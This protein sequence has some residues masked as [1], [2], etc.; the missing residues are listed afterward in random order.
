MCESQL[1]CEEL[2]LAADLPDPAI[3]PVDPSL[4][5]GEPRL[6]P[7][8]PRKATLNRDNQ[9][10]KETDNFLSLRKIEW[11]D[12]P[13]PVEGSFAAPLEVPAY[14]SVNEPLQAFIR[15]YT[16]PTDDRALSPAYRITL[17]SGEQALGSVDL[18]VNWSSPKD[19]EKTLALDP[20]LIEEGTNELTL[21]REPAAPNADATA[22]LP[23]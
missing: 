4:L 6:A 13:V 7:T 14:A 2:Q 23:R 22:A 8:T 3:A 17:K 9:L 19:F 5:A 11:V 20:A 18:N 10:F 15:F 1:F 16:Q 21:V 12:G